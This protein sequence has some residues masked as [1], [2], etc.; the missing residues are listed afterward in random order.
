MIPNVE[1][2]EVFRAEVGENATTGD[3]AAAAPVEHRAR[4]RAPA[5]EAEFGKDGVPLPTDAGAIGKVVAGESGARLPVGASRG[6]AGKEAGA[7]AVEG[8]PVEFGPGHDLQRRVTT[9]EIRRSV[10]RFRWS[11][12]AGRNPRAKGSPASGACREAGR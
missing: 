11:R 8:G 9:N 4:C 12:G 7:E 10:G 5:T 1:G 6:G 3:A 2:V